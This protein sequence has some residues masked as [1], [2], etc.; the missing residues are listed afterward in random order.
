M[1][2]LILGATGAM[3]HYLTKRA[4]EAGDTV[5]AVSLMSIASDRPNLRYIQT[6]DARDPQFLDGILKNG[7]DAVVDFM[8]YDSINFRKVY[9]KFLESCGRYVYLSSCR[10]YAN[11]ENPIRED[12]P[13]L[14]DVTTDRDLLFS[15]DYCIHKARGEDALRASRYKNWTI[16]RPSTT[17]S[18]G[19][20][21]LVTLERPEIVRCLKAGI[22]VPLPETAKDIPASLTWGGDVAEMI[23]RLLQNPGTKA[24]DYNVTTS[25][26]LS[27]G[28]IAEIYRD[29]M[30]IKYEW[31]DEESYF[32][33][34]KPD[35]D[36]QKDT[37][38]L[39]QLHYA[40]LFNRV[41][42]NSKMLNAT[43]LKN[44][45]F[46]TLREGLTRELPSLTV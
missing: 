2:V 39:W 15:D 5:D 40:R 42:D 23:Y 34:K 18:T 6:K 29:L 13:R 37:G 7:Y 31:V 11:E 24:E 25:E 45:D 4:V 14:I 33:F 10:V 1:K 41:Y 8:I 46:L 22:P 35:F 9:R 19:R 12:S 26:A 36:P 17:Y 16:I 20:C 27:W 21:Q 44:V 32:R 38:I 30:G 3:G 43:G 28:E